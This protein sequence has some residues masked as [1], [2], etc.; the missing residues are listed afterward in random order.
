MLNL[1][2]EM[3]W[4]FCYFEKI[5]SIFCLCKHFS[6]NQTM[7]YSYKIISDGVFFQWFSSFLYLDLTII[8]TIVFCNPM[9]WFLYDR[10][11]C[12]ERVKTSS[13]ST[14]KRS[15]PWLIYLISTIQAECLCV[16]VSI[17]VKSSLHVSALHVLRQK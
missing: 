8:L 3:R 12:R 15:K 5:V 17:Q 6:C 11:L 4:L 10:D 1:W 9:D 13:P 7:C 14:C 2:C 16:P